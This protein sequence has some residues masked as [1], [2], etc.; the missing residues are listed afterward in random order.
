M[1]ANKNND[2]Q[3]RYV[4]VKSAAG[5]ANAST[6]LTTNAGTVIS[7]PITMEVAPVSPMER[8]KER[9]K[10]VKIPPLIKGSETVSIV[11]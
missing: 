11:S 4:D 7:L 10:P 3:I 6:I 8:V 5:K 2:R 9:M 1:I